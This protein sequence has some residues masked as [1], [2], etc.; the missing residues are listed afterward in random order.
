MTLVDSRSIRAGGGSTSRC[1]SRSHESVGVKTERQEE[2]AFSITE[3]HLSWCGVGF[4][5]DAGTYVPCS[6]RVDPHGRQES[7]RRPVTH[8]QAVSETARSD[9]SCVQRDTYWPA[10]HETPLVLAQDQVLPEGKLASHDQGH[11]AVPMGL[12]HVEEA[13]VLVYGSRRPVET[14]A[15]ARGMDTSPRSGEVNLESVWPGLGVPLRCSGDSAMSPLVLSYSSSSTGVGCYG[16]DMAEA[17][18][19]HLS[20]DR[21]TPGSSGESVPGRGQST[22]GSTVLAVLF[23]DLISL[24]DDSPWEIPIQ[25]GSPLTG[26]RHPGEPLP[27]VM[28]TVGVA[29]E[30]SQLITSGLPNEVDETILQSR[31]PSM[32][33]LYALHPGKGQVF[34]VKYKYEFS[35]I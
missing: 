28:E 3:N 26:R 34:F 35:H 21:S 25:E 32:R 22:S 20:P 14:G 10:V 8:C 7:E 24:L 30:G 31:A 33:K 15:E 11:A 13:L 5:Q 9:G 1:C 18:S 27:G 2:C 4:D 29:P 19:V 16:T 17:S 23:S 12:R 6:D